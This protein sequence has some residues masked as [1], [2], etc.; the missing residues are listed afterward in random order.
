MTE[1]ITVPEAEQPSS[2]TQKREGKT[3]IIMFWLILIIISSGLGLLSNL[4]S[5]SGITLI[6]SR[7]CGVFS[8]LATLPVWGLGILLYIAAGFSRRYSR[9]PIFIMA[10]TVA[11]S[12]LIYIL[13][14]TKAYSSFLHSSL[15]DVIFSC[16]LTGLILNIIELL[17]AIACLAWIIY[18]T[19]KPVEV[20]PPRYIGFTLFNF[21]AFLLIPPVYLYLVACFAVHSSSGGFIQFTPTGIHSIIKSY[22]RDDK[23][24]MLVGMSHIGNTDFFNFYINLAKA[25][26]PETSAVLTEGVTDNQSKLEHNFDYTGISKMVGLRSQNEVHAKQQQAPQSSNRIHADV[27]ISTFSKPTIKILNGMGKFLTAVNNRKSQN[28]IIK[29]FMEFNMIANKWTKDDYDA[30]TNDVLKKRND[31]LYRVLNQQ[32]PNYKTL[33]IPWG[34]AHLSDISK[35]LKKA[36]FKLKEERSFAIINFF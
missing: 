13:Y 22:E 14:C 29:G 15:S 10:W 3:V 17:T 23:E 32:L 27:D 2:A 24:V 4:F 33:V 36:G 28:D 18:R 1:T 5:F 6:F 11:A 12:L 30:F 35:R 25:R 21:I 7:I 26:D 34:A 8:F 31:H 9:K 16:N 19:Q 20:P